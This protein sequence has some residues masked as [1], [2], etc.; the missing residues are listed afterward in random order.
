MSN[1]LAIKNRLKSIR[2]TKKITHA[3]KLV[4]ISE[5]QKIR[6]VFLKNR[7]YDKTLEE[8]VHRV[9][10][11]SGHQDHPLFKVTEDTRP[12]TIVITSDLGLAGAY[13]QNIFKYLKDNADLKQLYYWI[14]HK[15]YENHKKRNYKILNDETGSKNLNYSDLEKIMR[16]I[17]QMYY[18]NEIT[19]ISLLYTEYVNAITFVPK[20]VTFLPFDSKSMEDAL[21]TQEILFQ[22][23]FTDVVAHLLPQYVIGTFYNRFLEAKVSEFASRRVAMENATDNAEDLIDLLQLDFNKARQAAITADLADMA[24]HGDEHEETYDIKMHYNAS[25]DALLNRK[26]IVVNSA[27]PM[28]DEQVASL[29]QA[30]DRVLEANSVLEVFVDPNLIQGININIDGKIIEGSVKTAL[31]GLKKH[32]SE[33]TMAALTP[34][35]K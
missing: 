30:L 11:S 20:K 9:I 26:R 25:L 23:N 29:K 12:L 7:E 21:P 34:K 13:N 31:D 35:E 5:L 8:I 33:G 16:S 14:G 32:L 15:G 19:S 28:D 18:R 2:S 4:A 17:V 6:G 10:A 1:T 24:D 27:Y 22:P 3:M